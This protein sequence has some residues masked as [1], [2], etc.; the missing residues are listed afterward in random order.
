MDGYD[1]V[2]TASAYNDSAYILI[3][4]TLAD[5]NSGGIHRAVFFVRAGTGSPSVFFDSSRDSGYSVDNLPS[6]PPAPFVAAYAGGATHLHWGANSEV[7]LWY[8]KVHRGSTAGSRPDP[9]TSSPRGPTP[10]TQIP[11]R[12]GATTSSRPSM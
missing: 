8:Y 6:V 1:L 2:S 12:P 11:E 5:S 10:A 4:P 3:V 7:D 9:R